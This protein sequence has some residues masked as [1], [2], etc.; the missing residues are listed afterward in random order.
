PPFIFSLICVHRCPS[1]VDSL[2][3]VLRDS[4]FVFFFELKIASLRMA[5]VHA[6]GRAARATPLTAPCRVDSVVASKRKAADHGATE[7]RV[8]L[9]IVG[10]SGWWRRGIG[11]AA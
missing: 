7:L 8:G 5:R 1:V 11:T 3:L 6:H 9:F 10:G 4:W 2:L